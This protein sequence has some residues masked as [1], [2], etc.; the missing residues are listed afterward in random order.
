MGLTAVI[1]ALSLSLPPFWSGLSIASIGLVVG[2]AAYIARRSDAAREYPAID[3]FFQQVPCYLSI[4]DKDLN[5]IRAN[6]LFRRDFGNRLGEKCHKVYKGSNDICPNCPVIKTFADGKTYSTEETV[7]TKDG[8]PAR[9]IVYTTP[10]LDEKQNIT[11][12]M[13]MSTNITEI[14]KLQD[15]LEAG[16]KEYQDLFERVPCYISIQD[17]ALRIIKCNQRFEQEFGDPRGKYCYEVFKNRDRVCPECHA[18]K[19]LE[20]GAIHSRETTVIRKDGTP[21]RLVAYSSPIYNDAGEIEAVMEMSTDISQ[22]KRLE[23]ELADMGRTI[24]VM[25]HRIKNILMGLEGGIFVVNAGMEDGDDAMIKKGWGMIERNVANVS[26]IVKDLLYCSREREMN[27]EQCDPAPI[28]YSVYELFRGKAAHENINFEI[29]ARESLPNGRF[30]PEALHSLLTNLVTNAIDACRNDAIENRDRYAI[31]IRAWY[32]E[33]RN[34]IFEVEDNGTGI[35]GHVGE[36]V[37][38]DF[39]STKGRE[40]TGLGLLVAHKIVY[41]HG[42]RITFRSR[43]GHG[44]TFRV[45]FPTPTAA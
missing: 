36:S 12:V 31:V 37:F 14:K 8:R 18:L 44:T 45:V 43:E 6:Q 10:V 7:I 25:A 32:D 27:F 34:H 28:V 5:I 26:R 42:G 16:R 35:P 24:A 21:A 22:I 29:D 40:G 17:R 23:Q 19:T 41:E 1:V 3:R 39:F 11:G 4:Q 20:D 13:E 30:D 2:S 38:D 33:N 15:Q 9:M